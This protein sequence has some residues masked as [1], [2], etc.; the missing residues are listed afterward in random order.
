M[1]V[2]L[3]L[4]SLNFENVVEHAFDLASHSIVHL[5]KLFLVKSHVFVDFVLEVLIYL[6]E[7]LDLL[8][9]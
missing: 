2:C 7:L 4:D 6:I 9:V 5:G 3:G 1:L 8:L